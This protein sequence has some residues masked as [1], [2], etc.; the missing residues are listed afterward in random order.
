MQTLSAP[1][2]D[3]QNQ[4]LG[5]KILAD[6]A[7]L[8]ISVAVSYA[9]ASWIWSK[10]DPH[11]EEK[12]QMQSA[13]R[14]REVSRRLGR[15]LKTSTF[16]DIIL[17]YVVRADHISTTLDD[18]GGL[19]TVK[20]DLVNQ[21]ILP[22][23]HPELYHS[24]LLRPN[25]GVLLY[26]EPGTGKTML[27]KALAKESGAFFINIRPSTLQSKWF[28]DSQRLVQAVFSLAF[29]LQPCII[30][31]DEVDA[32][33]GRRHETEHEAVLGLKNEFMQHWDGFFSEH[34]PQVVVL[35]ATN[36]PGQ[37][38]PAVM[39][40]FTLQCDV[41]LPDSKARQEILSR[42]LR[43]H[44]A[45]MPVAD[46]LSEAIDAF[47]ARKCKASSSSNAGDESPPSTSGST[48]ALER[49]AGQTEDCT[50]SDLMTLC[51]QAAHLQLS[52]SS[53]A[54]EEAGAEE[55]EVQ[56]L[57]MQHFEEVLRGFMPSLVN[58]QMH[59]Q[60]QSD[61]RGSN[62]GGNLPH[63]AAVLAALAAASGGQNGFSN[64]VGANDSNMGSNVI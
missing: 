43:E 7:A 27:A 53:R 21:V 5:R 16:E 6:V 58:S 9:F 52:A 60:A 10:F 59:R 13:S 48:Q 54:A 36:R 42:L 61:L 31:L 22:L 45:T 40:R 8:G 35:G 1:A 34:F 20:A 26:G 18:L 50:G 32:V 51:S 3:R 19:E 25:R 38:D 15:S 49:L 55:I 33:L 64:P 46:E 56:P 11:N 17:G 30:F 44:A 41:G 63:L 47:Q 39:R 14:K 62:N 4:R 28:G 23:Q 57:S 12:K 37:L 2:G 24:P 29:K